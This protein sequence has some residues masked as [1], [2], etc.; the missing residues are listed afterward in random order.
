MAEQ[1]RA[2][3]KVTGAHH[4]SW[5]KLVE[6][7][8]PDDKRTGVVQWDHTIQYHPQHV[9]AVL[10]EMFDRAGQQHDDETLKRYREALRVVF[11]ENVHLLAAAGTSHAMAVDAYQ[12]P[13]N[14]V[15]DEATTEIE[16]QNQLDD[17]I[18][19]LGLEAIAPRITKVRTEATYGQYVPAVREF[20]EALGRRAELEG[21]EV[22]RQM[23]VVN[24]EN[25]YRVA[26]ELMYDANKLS[27]LV[28]EPAKAAAVE[29]I[30][31]A[32]QGPFQQIQDYDAT[33]PSDLRMSAL[34]GVQADRAAY[35]TVREIAAYWSANQD[36]RR[37]MEAGLGATP[38]LKNPE[39]PSPDQETR[40][41]NPK[42]PGAGQQ[43]N[44]PT[45]GG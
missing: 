5:N 25:K 12:V 32:M 19:E 10:Q 2:A 20:S 31:T 29:R 26:A 14:Q 24:A 1:A 22:I 33:D 28:P 27:D 30:A 4:S 8:E 18:R 36:L 17:Y 40:P 13:A 42:A 16:T 37:T 3:V 6:L 11:H 9:V 7:L 15:L 34:A 45:R 39:H 35:K 38:P 44:P 23:A 43:R 41:D 21:S